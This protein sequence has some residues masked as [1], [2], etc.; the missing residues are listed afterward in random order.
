MYEFKSQ[1]QG[2]TTEKL[3]EI[4]QKKDKS[5]NPKTKKGK[6]KQLSGEESIV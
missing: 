4:L 3:I 2:R 5:L 1:L 6:E